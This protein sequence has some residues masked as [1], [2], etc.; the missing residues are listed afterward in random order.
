MMRQ[1]RRAAPPKSTPTGRPGR[2]RGAVR[3]KW[4]GRLP[5]ALLFP[6]DY[7]VGMSNL[8]FQLL[9][10]LLNRDD[11]IVAERLFMPPDGQLPRSLESGRLLADFPVLFFSV[12]FEDD[13]PNLVAMLEQS[14]IPPLAR[15]R[16]G[17]A[18]AGL[19][20]P[21]EADSPARPRPLVV[22]GGVACFINPEPLAPFADLMVIGEAEPVLPGLLEMLLRF[23]R[24]TERPMLLRQLATTLPGCYVPA[25]YTPVYGPD[26]TLAA[27]V[28]DPALPGLPPRVRRVALDRVPER[29]AHSRLLT[30]DAEFADLFMVELGRGCSR[31][32][33]FCAAGFV[34]RPPRLWPAEAVVAGLADRPDGCNRVGLLGMEM[35]RPDDLRAIAQ[36]LREQGCSLSFSSLRADAITPE[37]IALLAESRLQSAAIAPDGGSERLRRVIN[38]GINE[39]D[40]L[41]AAEALAT[42]GV[43]NIKLYFMIGLPTETMADMAELTAL[44][45]K[46]KERVVAAGRTRG[47]LGRLTLSVNCF[48]PKPWT[49][50]QFHP[51][52]SIDV[53]K[54]K[55]RYLRHHLGR[56]PNIKIKA[57]RPEKAFLQAVLARG[58]RRLAPLLL[59]LARDRANWQRACRDLDIRPEEYAMRPRPQEERFPWEIVD[60]GLDR[61]YLWSEYRRGLEAKPGWSCDPENCRRCGVC[62]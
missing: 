30:P 51:F 38:K 60:H 57:D 45:L 15:D 12:S 23:P 13:Y 1:P 27:M 19:P 47:R 18:A 8:G 14:G 6:N 2:E 35:A 54:E 55:I 56:E 49:P 31:G 48:V 7:R 61:R 37:L 53:L 36:T 32:C 46:V 22:M 3:K 43:M 20:P 9:Y 26:H 5:I 24:E 52:E 16:S 10:D 4:T 39:K 29:A 44:T 34:Y 62:R 28:P 11:R 42:A 59:E 58:D 40:I 25:L 41:T 50:F 17:P 33:R 21:A